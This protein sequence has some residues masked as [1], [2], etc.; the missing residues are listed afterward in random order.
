MYIIRFHEKNQNMIR[1]RVLVKVRIFL[2]K[3]DYAI[4]ITNFKTKIQMD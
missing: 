4:L 2:L 1:V 3:S